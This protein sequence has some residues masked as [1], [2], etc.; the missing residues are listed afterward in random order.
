M[1]LL[2]PNILVLLLPKHNL[3][4]R[5]KSDIIQQLQ[6]EVLAMQGFKRKLS[7]ES[8]SM[9]L[10]ELMASFPDNQFPTGVVHEFACVSKE[11]S[12]TTN[13][14]I[15]GLVSSLVKDSGTCLWISTDSCLFAPALNAFH[16]NP[17]QVI[18][19]NC[20]QY[21]D[22]LWA[23]EEALK[24]EALNA[25][26]CELTNL[27]FKESR[28]LQLAVEQSNVTGFIHRNTEKVNTLACFTRWH[29]QPLPSHWDDGTPGVGFPRWRVA[30]AKVKNGR[31][32]TWDIEW[33]GK[34]FRCIAAE[35]NALLV[36]TIRKAV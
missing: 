8:S 31:P 25:V 13:G 4:F 18:F 17:L 23:T 11:E 28:R 1:S 30:L 36:N 5:E 12:A 15:A 10:E 27:S 9:G 6:N 19:I 3:L 7:G 24:C 14:F 2:V 29:I 22:V 33:T 20:R 35:R 21:K 26:V 16:V 34:Q 32:G